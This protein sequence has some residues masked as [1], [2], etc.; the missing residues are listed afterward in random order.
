MNKE[1]LSESVQQGKAVVK[2][3][4]IV[5]GFNSVCKQKTF[6]QPGTKAAMLQFKF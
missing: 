1:T 2:K 5:W 6:I 4:G 3:L